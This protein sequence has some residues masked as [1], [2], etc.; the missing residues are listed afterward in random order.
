MLSF[1]ICEYCSFIVFTV[2]SYGTSPDCVR[3]ASI[4]VLRCISLEKAGGDMVLLSSVISALLK[5]ISGNIALFTYNLVLIIYYIF[6]RNGSSTRIFFLVLL[7]LYL[8][9][10]SGFTS[11][12]LILRYLPVT[13]QTSERSKRF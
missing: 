10:K 3:E 6:I 13:I 12:S 1:L 11:L 2:C 9:K 5:G 4:S 7:L 8:R